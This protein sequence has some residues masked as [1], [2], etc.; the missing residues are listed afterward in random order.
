M[1]QIGSESVTNDPFEFQG[2]L[3]EI[4][5]S[6]ILS[7]TIKYVYKFKSNPKK[8]LIGPL[9]VCTKFQVST[10]SISWYM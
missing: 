9:N 1:R 2:A 7:Q 6:Q 8:I 3:A 10:L 4:C 5:R